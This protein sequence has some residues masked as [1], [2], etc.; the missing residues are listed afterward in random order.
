MTVFSLPRLTHLQYAILRN[1]KIDFGTTGEDLRAL[2]PWN[3]SSPAFYQLMNH[4]EKEQLVAGDYTYATTTDKRRRQ[5]EYKITQAGA[6]A[7]MESQDFYAPFSEAP[8]H[9]AV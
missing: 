7:V 5:R 1:L 4:L 8:G 6:D 3:K 9:R 2:L